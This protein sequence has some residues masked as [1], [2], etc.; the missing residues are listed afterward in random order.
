MLI[1]NERTG[2]ALLPAPEFG[3]DGTWPPVETEWLPLRWE[4]FDTDVT[5]PDLGTVVARALSM[6]FKDY[7]NDPVQAEGALREDFL[8]EAIFAKIAH[9][10]VFYHGG[11]V[12]IV[13]YLSDSEKEDHIFLRLSDDNTVRTELWAERKELR[14]LVHAVRW[15][16]KDPVTQL[17]PGVTNKVTHSITTG[18]S[19]EHSQRLA[20]SLG[21]S[22]GGKAGGVQ[23]R[24]SSQLQ[25]EF[26][27]KVGI[28]AQ[29]QTSTELT[30]G[31][32]AGDR[33][34]IYAMWHV[35]HRIAVDA[36]IMPGL[37]GERIRS[38]MRY[39][40]SDLMWHQI[41]P[42][43]ESRGSIE[44]VTESDPYITYAEITRS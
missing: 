3:P 2:L 5:D 36:L 4:L 8:H 33:Y 7:V 43:W 10:E 23:A 28:S 24:L 17:P 25:Q 32:Q 40:F 42:R 38:K 21:L 18:L 14:R 12:G 44:F 26:G 37:R 41:L 6:K 34:R 30:L 39:E 27:L 9:I 1:R 11:Q 19:V 29:E 16:R 13:L 35:D 20:N 15:R 22:L 31:S